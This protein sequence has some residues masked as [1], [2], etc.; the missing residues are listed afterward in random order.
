MKKVIYN[1]FGDESV[2]EITEQPVPGPEKDQVLVRVKAVSI[3][4]LDWKI[5]GG[6]MKLMSGSKFPKSIGI[7]FAGSVVT[8]GANAE[9]RRK[10]AG[11]Q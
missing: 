3:N 4:P 11:W 8:H 10:L 9:A 5:Y 6:E 1:A 7:D 2:L